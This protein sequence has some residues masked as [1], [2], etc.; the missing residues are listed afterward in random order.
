MIML[1]KS[2][3]ELSYGVL[4]QRAVVDDADKA[5][6]QI[7]YLGY[8]VV[9][10]G[11]TAAEMD[12]IRRI[13]DETH[14]KYVEQYGE[15]VLRGI[16]EYNGIRLPLIF[17]DAF[18]KLATNAR[19]IELVEKLIQNKFILNQQNAIINPPGQTYNQALWHRDLPYQHFVSSKP[20]A[21]NALY[22]VDEFTTQNGATFVLPSSHTQDAFPSDAYVESNATQVAAPAGCFIVLDCMVFHRGGPNTTAVPRRAVN[23]MYTTAFIKQQIDIPSALGNERT[24]SPELADLLGFRYRIPRT[25]DE[26][27]R[28]RRQD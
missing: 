3:K 20:L 5:A 7:T 14:R 6:E 19:V 24:L 11:Y 22:C 9:E 17:N 2:Q 10:S 26:F 1:A 15:C 4:D 16:D 8:A 27:L 13:F 18:L 12:G 25:V 23:H 28:S 21:V